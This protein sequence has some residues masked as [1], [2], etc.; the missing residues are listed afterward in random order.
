MTF[1]IFKEGSAGI[2]FV[3]KFEGAVKAARALISSPAYEAGKYLVL[4]DTS[5]T[6]VKTV[7]KTEKVSVDFKP[8]RKRRAV[9][10]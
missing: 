10:S 4:A 2:A 1:Y 8:T 3:E 9:A 7:E 6:V 5:G